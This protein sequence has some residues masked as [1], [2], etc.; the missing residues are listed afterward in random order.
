MSESFGHFVG[1]KRAKA[2]IRAA[3]AVQQPAFIWGAP[4]IG[5]SDIA[6]QLGAEMDAIVLD[7]RLSLWEPTDLKGIPYYD[8]SIGRMV[9][10]IPEELPSLA[11]ANEHRYII[12][13]LDE[14]SSALPQVQAAA[15]QLVLNRRVGKYVLPDNVLLLAAGNRESDRSVTYRMPRA[16]ANRFTHLK[17]E[18]NWDDWF[19]WATTNHIHSDI[20]GY[21]TFSKPSL[22]DFD[23]Q[24]SSLAF[25]TPRSWSF[26]NRFLSNPETSDDTL[27][28]LI[29]GTVGEGLAA[30]FM[31]HRRLAGELPNPKDILTRKVTTVDNIEVSASYSLSVGMCYE[32]KE[33]YE[34][35]EE[36][37]IDQADAYFSFITNNFQT[38]I[39][40]MSAKMALGTYRFNIDYEEVSSYGEFLDK[41]GRYISASYQAN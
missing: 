28:D 25:A 31:A 24:S 2:A 33:A 37:W 32:L 17:L 11:E 4:G 16:L 15:Y 12:M 5:K 34:R 21:L 30:A 29:A 8:A 38:E 3:F 10:G 19:H 7:I 6:Q 26:V 14:L 13:F 41:Y 22:Y 23:P 9:W 40:I 39:G 18:V 35:R 20:V 27:G 1:P 36:N